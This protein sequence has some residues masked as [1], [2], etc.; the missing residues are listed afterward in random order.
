MRALQI[1]LLL[2]LLLPGCAG[3]M[4]ESKPTVWL[5]LEPALPAG[6]ARAGAPSLEVDSFATAAAFRSDQ[7]SVRDG[8]SRWTYTTYHRWVADP[9]EMVAA[10]ARDHLSR[11]GR[12]GA[13]F[14]PPGPV[15]ADYRLSGA[16]RGLFWD[17]EKHLAVLE[18]EVTLIALPETL[19]GFWIYRREAPVEGAEVADFTLAASAALGLV[20]ADLDRDV[21]GVIAGAQPPESR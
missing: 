19:R 18:A 4:R 20:L 8:A 13:V 17:R 21:G 2:T 16:V 9:G 1:A 15:E 11:T 7:V 14:T 12:F 10:A 6:G 5:A 3:L